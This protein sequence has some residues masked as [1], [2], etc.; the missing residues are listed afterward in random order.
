VQ[1]VFERNGGTGTP[2][3]PNAAVADHAANV[4]AFRA[5]M[6]VAAVLAFAGAA[7]GAAWISNREARASVEPVS[8]PA[9][10]PAAGS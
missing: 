7:V 9:P 8:E 3:E 6:L 1:R 2:L 4:D 10:A 5:G